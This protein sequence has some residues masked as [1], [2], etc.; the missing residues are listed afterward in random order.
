[1]INQKFIEIIDGKIL[2]LEQAK[3]CLEAKIDALSEMKEE[4]KSLC[5]NDF[6]D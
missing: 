1:M 2:E 4:I 3:E 5:A 6:R